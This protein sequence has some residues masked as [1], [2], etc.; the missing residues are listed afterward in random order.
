[1]PT[2]NEEKGLTE[3]LKKLPLS[4]LRSSGHET[5]ILVVD[6]NSHDKTREI[7][8]DFGA[9]VIVEH[10][11]GYGHAYK[12]GIEKSKGDIIITLDADGTYPAEKIPRFLSHFLEN[13]LDFLSVNRFGK[14]YSNTMTLTHRVGNR[15]LSAVMRKMFD[16]K[17]KDSQSGMWIFKKDIMSSIKPKSNGMSF[18]EEIKIHAFKKFKAAEIDGE[19]RLRHG[20]VKLRTLKDGLMNLLY[21]WIIKENI[22]NF[23]PIQNK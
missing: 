23:K 8:K 14:L 1:M 6:G 11:N 19:Y 13:E 16:I 17:I 7:A 21:Y 2:L 3:T 18:S 15:I 4:E 5:E 22:K 20:T 12:I 9:R 10:Q